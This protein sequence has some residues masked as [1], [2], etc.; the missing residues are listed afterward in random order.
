M[1]MVVSYFTLK[2]MQLSEFEKTLKSHINL[3]ELQLPF[4][5]HEE[6]LELFVQ[7]I[8]RGINKRVTL[9]DAQ[10]V[11]LAESDRH[12]IENME[13]HR[14]RPEVIEALREPFGAHIRRSDSVG[15]DF[16]YVAKVVNYR[17]TP[18]IVRLGMST[19]E[20]RENFLTLW[21]KIAIIFSFVLLFGF[22][23]SFFIHR[24]IRHELFKL[25]N[26]L[27]AIAN[28]EY[29]AHI[30]AGFAKEFLE[31]SQ[32]V[33]QL[34]GKLAK[35]DKQK[36]KH[37]AKLR[38]LSKQR[39][40][41]IAAVGHEFKNPIAS[42]MGY[43]QTLLEDASMDKEIRERFLGK[44]VSNGQKI[45][46]MI[47]RLSLATKLENGDL[48]P[49][50]TSFDLAKLTKEVVCSFEARFPKR[51]FVTHLDTSFVSADATMIEMVLNNLLDNALKY[52]EEKIYVEVVD[53]TCRIRDEGE[54]I[55]EEEIPNITKKFYRT[56]RYSWD[57]SMGLGLS[58]VHYILKLHESEL[59]IQST[60][61]EGS[62][63]S[64]TLK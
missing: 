8:K 54:G 52:S 60:L 48:T 5:S 55:P 25:S 46:T 12:D 17:G 20:I 15:N 59:A 45:N 27:Q 2:E 34:A 6:T 37:T 58:L 19:Q 56:N 57:N 9:I 23:I 39:S 44:I 63:F 26:G 13:N 14:Y 31:I 61:G 53:K 49:T 18:L 32:R 35:R 40:D 47:N 1:S 50:P 64:F 33:E 22:L 38:L 36:R 29:K 16:L 3:I 7:A 41:I 4:S 62:T 11:V 51:T 10:G 28:K 30:N 21:L 43:A 24:R 42:I